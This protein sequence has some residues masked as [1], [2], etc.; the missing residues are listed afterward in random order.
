MQK[1]NDV[2]EFVQGLNFE[3]L[4]PLKNDATKYFLFFE[5]SS[6][7]VCTSRKVFDTATAER[8]RGL[9]TVYA[10]H[11][12]YRWGTLSR[13]VELQKATSFPSILPVTSGKSAQLVHSWVTNQS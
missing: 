1:E 5:G 7:E 12:F 10:K 2:L 9:S 4:G 3:F 8:H 6:G 13:D 11:S